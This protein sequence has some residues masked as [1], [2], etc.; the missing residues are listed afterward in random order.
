M[1]KKSKNVILYNKDD[2]VYGEYSSIKKASV[3]NSCSENTIIRALRS[4]SKL[5]KRRLIVKYK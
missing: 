5:L 3:N 1:R 4:E 2:T